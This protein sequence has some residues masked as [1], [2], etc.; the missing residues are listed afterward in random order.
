[1]NHSEIVQQ[2]FNSWISKDR[3]IVDRYFAETVTYIECYG[4]VYEGLTQVQQWFDDWNTRG[5]V[6]EWRIDKISSLENTCFVEWFFKC[7]YE[8]SVG[9]FDGVSIVEFDATNKI[10]LIKE[11]QSKHDHHRPYGSLDMSRSSP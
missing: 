6:L 10:S 7:D 3:G 5:S 4:P 11:Y 2:Y 8:G 9:Y 1:M